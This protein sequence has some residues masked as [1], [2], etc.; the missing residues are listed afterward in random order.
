M[1]DCHRDRQSAK[2]GRSQDQSCAASGQGGG[3]LAPAIVDGLGYVQALASGIQAGYE[4]GC[5]KIGNV[6]NHPI[7]A[8]LDGLVFPQAINAPSHHRRVC[9]YTVHQFSQRSAQAKGLR[10]NGT[11][12]NRNQVP[13][14][15]R[16]VN[17]VMVEI[18]HCLL[19]RLK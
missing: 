5:Q 3:K 15:I 8:G 11:I 16:V 14:L 19:P 7:I 6:G 4:V 13:E 18:S 9:P 17:L 10:V 1:S 12:D 2:A